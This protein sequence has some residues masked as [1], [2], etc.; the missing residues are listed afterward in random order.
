MS[1]VVHVL[2]LLPDDESSRPTIQERVAQA[3]AFISSL[4]TTAPGEAAANGVQE[5]GSNNNSNS[6]K[7]AP[8]L[9]GPA[10][11]QVELAKRRLLLGLGEE[12]MLADALLQYHDRYA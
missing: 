4:P 7:P 10:L 12:Q 9:R 6:S 5:S 8:L 1:L 3:E 2:L 11:A